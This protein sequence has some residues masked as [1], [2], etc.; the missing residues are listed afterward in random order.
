MKCGHLRKQTGILFKN[1][2]AYLVSSPEMRDATRVFSLLVTLG[3][4]NLIHYEQR[5]SGEKGAHRMPAH[6]R[7]AVHTPAL[8]SGQPNRWRHG[9]GAVQAAPCRSWTPALGAGVQTPFLQPELGHQALLPRG[10]AL[11]LPGSCPHTE[12]ASRS[13]PG[14]GVWQPRCSFQHRPC[15]GF[16]PYCQVSRQRTKWSGRRPSRAAHLQ[17]E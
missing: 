10:P 14:P 5:P 2:L 7:S 11:A 1:I 15:W 8:A 12:W 16:G 6:L 9:W 17:P 3:K 13:L 4:M